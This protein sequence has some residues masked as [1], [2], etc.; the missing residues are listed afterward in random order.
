MATFGGLTVNVAVIGQG[1]VA[2]ALANNLSTKYAVHF[3]CS[4]AL[5]AV[6]NWSD[7]IILMPP[8]D[9]DSGFLKELA[10]VT[11][12][13]PVLATGN[14]ID[15]DRGMVGFGLSAAERLQNNLPKAHVVTA[16]D[17]VFV[18]AQD[19]F[20]GGSELTLFVAGNHTDAKRLVMQLGRDF[21]FAVV[22]AGGL[23]AARY[24][25]AA[26]MLFVNLAFGFAWGSC[27]GYRFSGC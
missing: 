19:L 2:C 11:K 10:K 12:G 13:K 16:F 21:G 25:E 7:L 15:S 9:W 26:A 5:K 6:A 18:P 8:Y 14:P 27:T 3:E 17:S 4:K 20:G 1:D 22:D 24:F 23:K